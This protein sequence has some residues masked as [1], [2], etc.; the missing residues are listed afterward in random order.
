MPN[1]AALVDNDIL[2]KLARYDLYSDFLPEIGVSPA[3]V[4][5]HPLAQYSLGLRDPKRVQR[6][7]GSPAAATR[8]IAAAKSASLV[9]TTHQEQQLAA[10]FVARANQAGLQIDVGEATLFAIGSVR[11]VSIIATGDKRSV[12]ALSTLQ[13][14]IGQAAALSGHILCLEQIIEII[15]RAR[16]VGYVGPRIRADSAAD[17]SVSACF[18]GVGTSQNDVLLNLARRTAELRARSGA[19]LMP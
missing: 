8:V 11:P 1:L 9:S 16:G 14:S 17:I 7:A 5:L 10:E 13:P 15:L 6:K 19:L 4:G 3:E 2:V 18:G 12:R